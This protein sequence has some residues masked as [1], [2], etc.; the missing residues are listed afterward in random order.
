MADLGQVEP[1]TPLVPLITAAHTS[2]R[3]LP[4]ALRYV[5]LGAIAAGIAVITVLSSGSTRQYPERTYRRAV[6]SL[7][8]D[9]ATERKARPATEVHRREAPSERRAPKRA[10]PLLAPTVP[11]PPPLLEPLRPAPRRRSSGPAPAEL[12]PNP[13]ATQ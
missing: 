4:S 6:G 2:K 11:P 7:A 13:Y 5:A 3:R 12:K 1:A 10:S 9:K 8:A